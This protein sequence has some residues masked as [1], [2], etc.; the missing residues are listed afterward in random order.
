MY[1]FA[2]TDTWCSTSIFPYA[3][4]LVQ[5]YNVG[6]QNAAT[7]AGILIASFALAEA[8]TSYLWGVASDRYGRKPVLL[9][10]CCGSIVSLLV[11]GF[12][13]SFWLALFGRSIGGLLNGNQGVVQ[14][15]VSELV[16][17]PAHEARAYAVMPFVW[18]VGTMLVSGVMP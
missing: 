10:G 15:M 17:N 13:D 11:V 16:T 1:P 9:F 2:L 12:S 3:W 18:S 14:T 4:R 7:Y 8:L 5:H 6:G